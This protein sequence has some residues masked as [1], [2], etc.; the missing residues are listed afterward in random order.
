MRYPRF[1]VGAILFAVLTLSLFKGYARAGQDTLL[2]GLIP[3]QNIFRQMDRFRPFAGYLSER[4]GIKVKLTILSRYGDIIDRFNQRKM[5]GAFFG[6]LTG[7]LAIKKLGVI[8]LVRSVNLDDSSVSRG[9]I[10]VRKDSGIKSI[11]D[12]KGR[13]MAFVDRAT[14]TGY[15]FTLVYLRNKGVKNLKHFFSEYYFTGSHDSTVYA[16]LDGRADIGSVKSTV[17]ESLT[18]RDPT[19]K[20]ELKVIAE[21]PP[22]PEGTLLVRKGLSDELK[23]R[24]KEVTLSMDKNKEGREVLLKMGLKGFVEAGRGD[25]LPVYKMIK[26][27]GMTVDDYQYR[28]K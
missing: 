7:A 28:V 16:V 26:R 12:M 17:F 24:I 4:L 15:L 14:V 22:M 2:L 23:R 11:A 3:E 8:P 6:D 21:S 18:K 1:I 27:L 10:I 9:Y 13:V 19:I 25:F 5:D 20:E